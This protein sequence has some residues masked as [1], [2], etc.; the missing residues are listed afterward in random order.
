MAKQKK[1]NINAKV[2][3]DYKQRIDLLAD[4]YGISLTELIRRWIDH[5][6]DLNE[7]S[8]KKDIDKKQELK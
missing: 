1:E 5:Y 2:N 4:H 8:L 3:A 6:W 7:N